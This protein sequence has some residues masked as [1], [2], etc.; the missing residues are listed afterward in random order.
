MARVNNP[1]FR[2]VEKANEYSDASTGATFLGISTKTGI[3]L[4]VA[5]VAAIFAG[6]LIKAENF[7]PLVAILSVSGITAFI[8]VLIGTIFPRV[9]M[10]FSILYAAAEG[11]MLGTITLLVEMMF[12]GQNIG[13][14]AVILTGVVFLVSLGLY[15]AKILRAT[16]K[17]RKFMM[18]SLLSMV[19][20]S[21]LSMLIPG[22]NA[23]FVNNSGLFILLSLVFIL[24]G[25]FML[26]INFDNASTIVE[27]GAEKHYE[28]T[29]SLGLMVTIVW[30][31]V[32]IL[33]LLVYLAARS[34]D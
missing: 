20:F 10:P 26:I 33:R 29:V 9:S 14:M 22:L 6:T 25:A 34:R 4:L 32:E 19:V 1:V 3:L 18:I 30:I 2:S 17:F 23:L 8:S 28:W 15:S 7:G 21:L 13:L 24:Y 5:V 11:F 12:P 31:Y 16:P 27:M